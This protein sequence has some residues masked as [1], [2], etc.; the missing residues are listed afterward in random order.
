MRRDV[1][2]PTGRLARFV[3]RLDVITPSTA[4]EIWHVEYLPTAGSSLLI[5]DR[6]VSFRGPHVRLTSKLRPATTRSVRVVFKPGCAYP[7]IGCELY[8]NAHE[9]I[10]APDLHSFEP[11]QLFAALEARLAK[12]IFDPPSRR[13]VYRAMP[14]LSTLSVEAVASEVG[15]STRQLRRA[16]EATTGL[17]PKVFARIARFHR[18]LKGD[19]SGYFDQS[20]MIAEF[21]AL[22]GQT[23][24]TL[25]ASRDHH[26]RLA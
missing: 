8:A 10:D 3:E 19:A 11:A 20:H 1:H 25:T 7:F 13:A 18:A 9:F 5:R 12:A 4:G 22:T 6:D 14:L 26:L 21:R 17:T 2:R 15:L 24:K 23:P 16:F